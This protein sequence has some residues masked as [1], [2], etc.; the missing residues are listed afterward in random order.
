MGK[1][2]ST[3][4]PIINHFASADD[5]RME[6]T[7]KHKL[8]DIIAT[9]IRAADGWCD[10]ET[11]GNAKRERIEIFLELPNGIPSRDTFERVFSLIDTQRSGS[12]ART[13]S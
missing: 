7:K 4:I 9:S 1:T 8:G 3:S 10:I 5:P 6:R 12:L 13:G 2:Q 11:F